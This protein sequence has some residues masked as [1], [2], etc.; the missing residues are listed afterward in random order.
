M[1]IGVSGSGG[2]VLEVG[3]CGSEE[4]VVVW[5]RKTFGFGEMDGVCGTLCLVGFRIWCLEGGFGGV[6]ESE[7]GTRDKVLMWMEGI[8][9]AGVF[10]RLLIL[11]AL[12]GAHGNIQGSFCRGNRVLILG[13]IRLGES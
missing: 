11:L 12:S 4:L 9:F 5:F 1:W 8:F 10:W 3:G 2:L 7:S 6:L 13:Y